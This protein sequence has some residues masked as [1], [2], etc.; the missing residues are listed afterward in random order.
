VFVGGLDKDTTEE[1]LKSLFQQVGDVVEVRLMRNSQT[2]KNK[3]YAFIR[4]ATTAMAKRA[5]EELQHIE[6][7]SSLMLS[8]T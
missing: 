8:K 6:V 3:G 4:Y 1:D 2:G 7:P 5:A